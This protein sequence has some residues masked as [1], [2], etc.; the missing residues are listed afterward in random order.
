MPVLSHILSFKNYITALLEQNV[1]TNGTAVQGHGIDAKLSF[2]CDYSCLCSLQLCL[3]SNYP[4]S[5]VKH[6][7]ARGHGQIYVNDGNL[8]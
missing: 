7:V 4:E 5:K 6:I 8:Q 3:G 1:N 2:D